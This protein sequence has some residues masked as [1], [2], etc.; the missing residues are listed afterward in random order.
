L[1]F[2]ASLPNSDLL[3]FLLNYSYEGSMSSET[4][5]KTTRNIVKDLVEAGSFDISLVEDILNDLKKYLYM[6]ESDE[7]IKRRKLKHSE[8]DDLYSKIFISTLKDNLI[9]VFGEQ[10]IKTLRGFHESTFFYR[11]HLVSWILSQ[12]ISG[13]FPWTLDVNVQSGFNL[14]PN[15]L[16]CFGNTPLH[17]AVRHERTN[18][19]RLLL[20]DPRT[21][22]LMNTGTT[23][24][25]C[26][27]VLLL[28][29]KNHCAGNL[30]SFLP[31]S[32]KMR[33]DDIDNVNFF[34]SMNVSL[35]DKPLAI[36]IVKDFSTSREI[37]D[38]NRL[39]IQNSLSEKIFPTE[40]LEEF[41][42]RMNE[43]MSFPER[44]PS[45]CSEFL[46]Q[47]GFFYEICRTCPSYSRDIDIITREFTL[48]NYKEN[49]YACGICKETKYV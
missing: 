40:R 13:C 26:L 9:R 43:N 33:Q 4:I 41:H 18:N 28:T 7:K 3:A 49:D 36:S 44:F 39:K 8:D 21:N 11:E 24:Y 5:I 29:L 1:H 35:V 2:A 30:K 31:S 14:Y 37:C 20:D 34:L 42:L 19:I 12:I 46:D 6:V 38:T 15:S 27:P 10:G 17:V 22:P 48:I 23:T 16:Y 47:N 45:I 25:M 32:Y